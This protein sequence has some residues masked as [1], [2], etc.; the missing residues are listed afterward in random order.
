MGLGGGGK[1]KA[2]PSAAVQRGRIGDCNSGRRSS[3]KGAGIT[4]R[5]AN[6]G[7]LCGLGGLARKANQVM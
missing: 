5:N 4:K 1:S 7:I 2:A 3:R 6:G